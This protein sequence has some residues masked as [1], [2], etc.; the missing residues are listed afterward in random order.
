MKEL[1]FVVNEN[2]VQAVFK[3]IV[4]AELFI[5]DFKDQEIINDYKKYHDS[6]YFCESYK[7][8]VYCGRH[9]YTIY[10]V[11]YDDNHKII[12]FCDQK[13]EDWVEDS[14]DENGTD[15]FNRV[16]TLLEKEFAFTDKTD[17]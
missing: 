17:D 5:L 11:E 13:F 2:G 4:N 14:A 6:K 12:K 15:E 8:Y 1:V 7:E 3:E 9:N 16:K 10:N